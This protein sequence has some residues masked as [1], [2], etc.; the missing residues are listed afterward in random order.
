[1]R[2]LPRSK[3]VK[4]SVGCLVIIVAV[5]FVGRIIYRLNSGESATERLNRLAQLPPEAAYDLSAARL[6]LLRRI[7]VG[8]NEQDVYAVLEQSGAIGQ[9]RVVVTPIPVLTPDPKATFP[10]Y[11]ARLPG[12]RWGPMTYYPKDEAG[13][14]HCFITGDGSPFGFGV[15]LLYVRFWLDKQGMLHDITVDDRSRSL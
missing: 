9:E 15:D 2:Q 3:L 4:R 6:A 8:T 11:V 13:V 10:V 14:I 1:V 12:A 5:L 7:P